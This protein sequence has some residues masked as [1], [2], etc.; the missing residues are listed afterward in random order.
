MW[1]FQGERGGKGVP[2]DSGEGREGARANGGQ[3]GAWDSES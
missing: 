1:V 2:G 3:F